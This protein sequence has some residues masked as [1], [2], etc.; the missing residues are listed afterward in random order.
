[1]CEN[2]TMCKGNKLPDNM[3]AIVYDKVLEGADVEFRS[4]VFEEQEK[5]C[6]CCSTIYMPGW[7][8]AFW[9]SRLLICD[10]EG[11]IV[12]GNRNGIINSKDGTCVA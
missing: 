11:N 7:Y 9:D 8:E 3:P 1:M 12:E 4:E 5:S 2:K 10:V 6:S